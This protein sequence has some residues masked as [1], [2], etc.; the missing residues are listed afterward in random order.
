[1]PGGTNG[2]DREGR[3]YIATKLGVQVLDQLGRCNWILARP[4][5]ERVTGVAFGGAEM[6]T[7]FITVESVF[8]KGN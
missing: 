4:D 6:D 5:S 7:L 8:T 3:L 1:M 2:G